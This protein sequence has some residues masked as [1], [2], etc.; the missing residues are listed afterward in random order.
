MSDVKTATHEKKAVVDER[1]WRNQYHS[2][3]EAVWADGSTKGPG[4]WWGNG[5]YTT[6]DEARKIALEFMDDYR[7]WA[8]EY[9]VTYRGAFRM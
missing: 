5:L 2:T 7:E 1:P 8:E 3:Q 6:E 4:L 9:G